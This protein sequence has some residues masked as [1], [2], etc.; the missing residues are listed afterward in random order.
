MD[1]TTLGGL[2][3]GQRANDVFSWRFAN[4]LPQGGFNQVRLRAVLF[5]PVSASL[6]HQL[7][8]CSDGDR[9][10]H[11]E[12]FPVP[13]RTILLQLGARSQPITRLAS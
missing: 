13:A 3:A 8:V 9:G 6:N 12:R 4:L 1:W 10:F 2:H 7:G 11:V 5:S